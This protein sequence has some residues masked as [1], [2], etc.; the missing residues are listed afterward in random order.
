MGQ[1]FK[2]LN[3][4][5]YTYSNYH[6][7]HGNGVFSTAIN[8]KTEVGTRYWGIAAIGLSLLSFEGMWMLVH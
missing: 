7:Y 2:P 4:W 3:L 5:G 1:A 8:P 6:S